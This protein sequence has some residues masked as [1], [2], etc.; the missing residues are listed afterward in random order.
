[1]STLKIPAF[2]LSHGAPNMILHKQ[3]KTTLFWGALGKQLLKTYNPKAI[4]IV[5]AHWEATQ[6]EVTNR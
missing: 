6:F 1:M 4:L 2:A 5:S 3:D